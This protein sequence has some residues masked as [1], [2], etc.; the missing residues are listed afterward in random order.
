MNPKVV[1]VIAKQL[2]ELASKPPDAVCPVVNYADALDIQADIFG[3][4]DTPYY[5]GVFR[6]KL[7]L[8]EDFPASAPKGYFM[9]KI[10]HPNVSEKG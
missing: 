6:V 2:G 9:T 5:K 1:G 10:F 8:E 3:P 7:V 4:V